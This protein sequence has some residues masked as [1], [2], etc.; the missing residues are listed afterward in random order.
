VLASSLVRVLTRMLTPF[1]HYSLATL[2]GLF[3]RSSSAVSLPPTWASE[4][5]TAAELLA[6]AEA[7]GYKRG[8][9][10]ETHEIR[11]CEKHVENAEEQ[12]SV[13]ID[14]DTFRAAVA[15]VLTTRA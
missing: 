5:S 10:E 9:H 8:S 12:I 6:R 1:H 11:R 2:I 15:R 3:L 14:N 7:N 13:D 4:I